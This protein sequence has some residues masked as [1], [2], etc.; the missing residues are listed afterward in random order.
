MNAKESYSGSREIIPE[1]NMELQKY[2]K[3]KGNGKYWD[4]YKRLFFQYK[5]FNICMKIEFRKRNTTRVVI[6]IK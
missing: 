4:K 5:F 3:Y 1:E 6:K 2:R